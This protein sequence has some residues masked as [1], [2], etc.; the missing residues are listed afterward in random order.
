MFRF[1]VLISFFVLALSP[2]SYAGDKVPDD[3][4]LLAKYDVNGDRAIT[5]DEIEY[6]RQRVFAHM[7]EDANGDVS[8]SE[9]RNLDQ[10]KRDALLQA[11]FSKLDANSDGRLTGA[12]YASYLGSF[13]RL[14]QNGDGQ[15]STHEITP[16]PSSDITEKPEADVCLLW[17]CVR[18]NFK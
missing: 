18:K 7:D 5:A 15:V 6:K 12:E 4:W 17:V 16:K 10:R 11:R 13:E 2:L 3:R 9:Y 8:F 14:D 1:R